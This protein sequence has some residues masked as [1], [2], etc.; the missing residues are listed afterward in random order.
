MKR[1][2]FFVTPA[3]AMNKSTLWIPPRYITT[4]FVGLDITAFLIQFLGLVVLA[5][6]ANT[7]KSLQDQISIIQHGERIL[8]LGLIAQLVGFGLFAIV[9]LRFVVRGRHWH[10][11]NGTRWHSL[12]WAING[13]A[14]IITVPGFSILSAW[15]PLY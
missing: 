9:G 15:G 14:T 10:T 13:C 7:D 12:A 8:K 3:A 11:Q 2:I 6:A 4:I 5:G 1:L